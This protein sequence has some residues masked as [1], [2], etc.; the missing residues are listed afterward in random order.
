MNVSK[1]KHL[2]NIARVAAVVSIAMFGAAALN[3]R[4]E[5]SI[6]FANHGGIYDWHPNGNKGIWVQAANRHWYY[7]TFFGGECFGLDTA[8]SVG[9]VTEPTGEFNRWSS[10]IVPRQL[11]PR[12]RL[13]TFEPSAAP[14]EDVRKVG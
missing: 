14:S 6:P 10:I 2:R 9:F 1:P 11:Q 13:A 3:A 4:A 5:P 8:P 12:C 7:A